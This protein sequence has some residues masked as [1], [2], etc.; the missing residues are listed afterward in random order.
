MCSTVNAE[1]EF[2]RNYACFILTWINALVV[3]PACANVRQMLLSGNPGNLI[4]SLRKNAKANKDFATSDKIRDELARLGISLK[5]T[6]DG[7]VWSVD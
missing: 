2:V 6:K 4:L 7:A 1:Q 3:L 5:D